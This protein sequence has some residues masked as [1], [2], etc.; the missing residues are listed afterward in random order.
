MERENRVTKE[1]KKDGEDI[2]DRDESIAP[3]KEEKKADA[4]N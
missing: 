4:E 2:S 1:E 3:E